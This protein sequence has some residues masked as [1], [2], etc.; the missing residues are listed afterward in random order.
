MKLSRASTYALYGLGYLASQPA[1]RFVPLSEIGSRYRIPH[2]HLAKIFQLLVRAGLLN[3][4]RGVN[5]GFALER[6][7]ESI[8]M[9]D[10]IEA[11]EG[12]SGNSNC[13]LCQTRCEAGQDDPISS[14]W[15]KAHEQ[16]VS[17]LRGSSLAQVADDAANSA[18]AHARMAVRVGV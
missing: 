11:V 9:L 13:L 2:K 5:G 1:G 7:P 3:S 10:V 6:D 18:R 15:H 4:A 12:R 16:M 17:V 14:L 8:S